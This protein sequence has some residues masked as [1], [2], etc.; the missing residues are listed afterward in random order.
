M[1]NTAPAQAKPA[2][3]K[4]T[5]ITLVIAWVLFLLPIPGAGLFVGWPLNLVAFILAIVVMTRG[6]T[7]GGLV[8]L[9]SSLVVSPIIYFIGLAI[10]G[11]AVGGSGYKDY[12]E[13]AK[14]AAAQA[15]AEVAQGEAAPAALEVT[16]EQLFADY[17]ANEVSADNQ[18]KGKT[19]AVSGKVAGIN[20]DFSDEI[21]VELAA[22]PFQSIQARGIPQD[23]AAALKKGQ[24]V[25][26][27]CV[28]DGLMMTL[29]MLKNCSLR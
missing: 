25:T 1:S 22:N 9:V 11:A 24:S 10:F 7:A 17:E 5:W 19:L 23:A 6:R 14:A 29:P 13:R 20:K 2:P 16:A 21:Y 27:E 8:P 18:Y 28:G 3:I 26:V 15:Q 12:A 4:A